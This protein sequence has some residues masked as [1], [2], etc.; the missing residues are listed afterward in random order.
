MLPLALPPV[1]SDLQQKADSEL[2]STAQQFKPSPRLRLSLAEPLT[3]NSS[4]QATTLGGDDDGADAVPTHPGKQMSL[5]DYENASFS[6]LAKKKPRKAE[7]VMKRPASN[8]A[9]SASGNIKNDSNIQLALGCP[10]CRGSINGCSTCK[11]AAYNGLRL[12]GK[13]AWEAHVKA[14]KQKQHSS[15]K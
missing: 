9:A 13:A 8:K 12:H 11:N 5:E 7:T 10:R 6:E 15:A 3:T 2:A 4:H 1:P 14:Q